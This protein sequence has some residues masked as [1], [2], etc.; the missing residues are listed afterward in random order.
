MK[1][2][3]DELRNLLRRKEPPA[4]FAERVMARLETAPLRL[5]IGQ[6]VS[7]FIGWP[8]LRWAAAAAAVCIVAVAG[9]VR[10]QHQQQM[11]AQAERASQQAILALRITN[12][13]I[14]A[15]LERAQLVTVRALEVRR[16]LKQEME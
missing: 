14:E 8:V 2:L 13:E 9:I 10:Y 3:D 7:A 5:T 1:P 15:A 4:G 11:R 12:E 16:N 6:R